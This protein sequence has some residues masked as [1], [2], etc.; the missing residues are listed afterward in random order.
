MEASR[1]SVRS[2]LV[3][4]CALGAAIA[5]L[6]IGGLGPVLPALHEDLHVSL[7]DLGVL[8]AANFIGSLGTT[9]VAGPLF[10]RRMPRPF[11]LTGISLMLC[12]LVL[13]S[14]ASTLPEV[15]I[16]AVLTGIGG[17]VNALGSTVLAARQ[18]GSQAGRALALV[19]MAFGLGAFLGPLAAA[20]SIAATHQYRPFFMASGVLLLLPMA[21]IVRLPLP[22]PVAHSTGKT[23]RLDGRERLAVGLLA[24]VAFCYLGAEIGFGGW[25]YS[26]VLQTGTANT[27]LASCAPAAYW[28]ALGLSSLGAALRPRSWRG[29]YVVVCAGIG[30]CVMTLV[31]LAGRGSSVV[32]IVA[33]GGVGL[34]LGPI[35]PLSLAGAALVAPSAAGR[36]SALVIASS[37]LGGALLPWLQGL[38]L[39]RGPLWGLGVT[40]G[41]CLAMAVVQAGLIGVLRSRS[42]P[43]WR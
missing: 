30:A 8:F 37:Q 6:N 12:G 18:F 9:I 40:L 14:L 23:A 21:I 13:F 17:G 3:A 25:I 42:A 7:G 15:I 29:E 27:T 39:A 41:A 34:A 5:G 38:L 33:A 16:A 20:A 4:A 35:Y 22:G 28:L 24:L 43:P 1:T 31:M 32:E 11:L 26:F 2:P 10:D 19:N 36:V